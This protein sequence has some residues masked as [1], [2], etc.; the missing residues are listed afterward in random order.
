MSE[1]MILATEINSMGKDG[2]T[3]I[4][5]LWY[6]R[7][8]VVGRSTP[9]AVICLYGFII[10]GVLDYCLCCMVVCSVVCWSHDI[11]V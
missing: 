8:G 11:G 3:G 1:L 7:A 6:G 4:M 9:S 10:V 2:S 5:M